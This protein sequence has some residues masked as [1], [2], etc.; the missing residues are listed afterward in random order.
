MPG[1]HWSPEELELVD[2]LYRDASWAALKVALPARS[3]KA[4]R[5]R[6]R[7][8]GIERFNCARSWSSRDNAMLECGWCCGFEIGYLSEILGRS[9]NAIKTQRAK[10]GLAPRRHWWTPE[11][12]RR[13]LRLYPSA[14]WSEILKAIPGR[15]K[16][17]IAE[18][19]RKL[20]VRRISWEVARHENRSSWWSEGDQ[21]QLCKG[22]YL[23]FPIELIAAL[24]GRPLDSVVC[25]ARK[26]GLWRQPLFACLSPDNDD[27][28]YLDDGPYEHY[29]LLWAQQPHPWDCEVA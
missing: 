4:I 27:V 12:D 8:R 21:E 11:E 25:R 14:P 20:G 24:L 29:D 3:S 13:V 18:R 9:G 16:P 2:L 7:K 6:G 28:N 19:A 10:I 17:A 15:S 23:G 1:N 22:L 26:T 5:L